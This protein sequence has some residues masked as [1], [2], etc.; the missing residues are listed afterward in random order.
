MNMYFGVFV[1]S[2][3]VWDG[4]MVFY[5]LCVMIVGYL[6]NFGDGLMVVGLRELG[7]VVGIVFVLLRE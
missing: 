4:G 6:G 5:L 7:V 3:M 1:K 2:V